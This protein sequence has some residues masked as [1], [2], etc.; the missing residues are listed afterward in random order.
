MLVCGCV[1]VAARK[2]EARKSE[3]EDD[4]GYH[5]VT[6]WRKKEGGD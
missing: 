4:P 1:S 5:S 6:R 3:E 2:I